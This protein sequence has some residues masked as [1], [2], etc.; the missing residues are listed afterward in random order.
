MK[1]KIAKISFIILSIVLVLSTCMTV[2]AV[3]TK[4]VTESQNGIEVTLNFNKQEYMQTKMLKLL[5][6]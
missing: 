3:T 4:T 6:M 2:F 5:L 1:N